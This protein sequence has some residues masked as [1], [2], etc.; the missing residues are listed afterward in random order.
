ME[1]KPPLRVRRAGEANE[2]IERIRK[3]S[4]Q[5]DDALAEWPDALENVDRMRRGIDPV[6]NQGIE[7]RFGWRMTSTL[8]DLS[9]TRAV[10]KLWEKKG[11]LAYDVHPEMANSLYRSDV[12]GTVPGSLFA[13]LRHINPA[14]PLPHPWPVNFG[15]GQEGLIRAYFLT[16][17]IGRAFCPTTDRRSEGLCLVPWIET[18]PGTPHFKNV[19]TPVFSLPV[20][21]GPFTLNDIVKDTYQWNNIDEEALSAKQLYQSRRIAKQIVPGALTLL[22]YL[23]CKNA[24]I[25]DRPP[26]QSRGKRT[27]LPDRDPYYIRVGWYI[28][29]KLHAS[30][31]RANGRMRDGI[32]VPSGVEYGPQ[33]RVGHMRTVWV[34]PG[35]QK[36]ESVW[37]D[38]YWTKLDQLGE[39]QEPVTQVVPVEPQHGDPSSHRDVKLANLGTQKA[40][41]I[42]EREAQRAR[43]EGWDF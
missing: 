18:V 33:H 12:K 6:W 11:R 35:R 26:V 42:R 27:Q 1:K 36:D 14:I 7:N 34:G 31:A 39:D 2:A 37:I 17:R 16:G 4:G 9:A 41:G 25:E 28:G 8:L 19:A 13:R 24:D 15:D 21:K 22:T 43:E 32:S 10:V 3:V 38:P 29:P 5:L 23:C 20:M 30:R 40:K